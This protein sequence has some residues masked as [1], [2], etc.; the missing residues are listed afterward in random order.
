MLQATCDDPRKPG[1][2]DTAEC[3]GRCGWFQSANRYVV[4]QKGKAACFHGWAVAATMG[5]NNLT[6]SDGDDQ[7]HCL[8]PADSAPECHEFEGY[9]EAYGAMSLVV[10]SFIICFIGSAVVNCLL[11]W[12]LFPKRKAEAMAVVLTKHPGSIRQ[13]SDTIAWSCY[14]C[15]SR[16][17]V[18]EF[19]DQIPRSLPDQYLQSALMTLWRKISSCWKQTEAEY[20]PLTTNFPCPDD[21]TLQAEAFGIEYVWRSPMPMSKFL[22]HLVPMSCMQNLFG[23]SRFEK[24]SV[25][26]MVSLQLVHKM[27][28]LSNLSVREKETMPQKVWEK[29]DEWGIVSHQKVAI[30]DIEDMDTDEDSDNEDNMNFLPKLQEEPSKYIRLPSRFNVDGQPMYARNPYK[31]G[32]EETV[33]Q[34]PKEQKKVTIG[35]KHSFQGGGVVANLRVGKWWWPSYWLFPTQYAP[36]YV[37]QLKLDKGAVRLTFVKPMTDTFS[38]ATTSREIGVRQQVSITERPILQH[39]SIVDETLWK[40]EL[41]SGRL[42]T[43][44]DSRGR[45]RCDMAA[46]F[47]AFQQSLRLTCFILINLHRIYRFWFLFEIPVASMEMPVISDPDLADLFNN[48][49]FL[50]MATELYY[51]TVHDIRNEVEVILI[52]LACASIFPLFFFYFFSSYSYARLLDYGPTDQANVA[53]KSRSPDEKFGTPDH[54]FYLRLVSQL[55]L[56]T[57]CLESV[58]CLIYDLSSRF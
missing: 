56:V 32:E 6:V 39:G 30:E 27:K 5:D 44:L 55:A 4:V 54:Y 57:M 25:M 20:T 50:S 3:S 15:V 49:P 12:R 18:D 10:F 37:K 11:W 8:A 36:H 33:Y 24:M 29:I 13:F 17:H 19:S 22:S 40:D 53:V 28:W 42:K 1:R 16:H 46:T 45:R 48:H 7:T 31:V 51:K 21:E 38:G 41:R 23:N 2:K 58:S 35:T 34:L 26:D 52:H 47:E 43:F 9:F 14:F